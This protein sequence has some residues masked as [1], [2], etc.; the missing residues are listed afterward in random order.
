M[1]IIGAYRPHKTI[2][3]SFYAHIH[4]E[5]EYLIDVIVGNRA[6]RRYGYWYGNGGPILAPPISEPEYI[7]LAEYVKKHRHLFAHDVG[8][9]KNANFHKV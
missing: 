3:E 9:Y 1:Y 7:Q 6:I 4:F 2:S 8:I 5:M